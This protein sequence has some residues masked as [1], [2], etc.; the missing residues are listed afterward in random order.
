[1][2]NRFPPRQ[3]GWTLRLLF[4]DISRAIR[5][6]QNVDFVSVWKD[7]CAQSS[8]ALGMQTF[9]AYPI[10]I[11]NAVKYRLTTL[12]EAIS[13]VVFRVGTVV[14][15]LDVS[16]TTDTSTLPG[17]APDTD[18]LAGKIATATRDQ[19]ISQH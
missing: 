12:G 10:E 18:D 1:M 5:R 8:Q 2:W 9:D 4:A 7:K 16:L 13:H 6:Q 15:T 17:S 19:M 11:P 3:P 14:A